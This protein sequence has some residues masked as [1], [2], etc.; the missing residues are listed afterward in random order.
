MRVSQFLAS[1][2]Q[3]G[4]GRVHG[5]FSSRE[6]VFSRRTTLVLCG[7]LSAATVWAGGCN[8]EPTTDG[9]PGTDEQVIKVDRLEVAC[10]TMPG[11]YSKWYFVSR[12]WHQTGKEDIEGGTIEVRDSASSTLIYEN[13]L[14][15][16]LTDTNDPNRADFYLFEPEASGGLDCVECE[17]FDFKVLAVDET[18]R[19]TSRG[20]T[21]EVCGASFPPEYDYD[22]EY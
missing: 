12:I 6:L 22:Y 19:D 1:Y 16:S 2:I 3:S 4:L 7:A 13:A 14:S 20:F 8:P 9:T 5:A 18:G 10:E 17:D 21:G 11:G 15:A